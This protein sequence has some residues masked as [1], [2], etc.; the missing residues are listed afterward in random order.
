MIAAKYKVKQLPL[1]GECLTSVFSGT[2]FLQSES[3][4]LRKRLDA[5]FFKNLKKGFAGCILEGSYH[6]NYIVIQY[7]YNMV[8]AVCIK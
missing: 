4:N 1:E 6:I 3:L 5:K 8:F 2:S 7:E